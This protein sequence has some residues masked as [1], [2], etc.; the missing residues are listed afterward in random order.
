MI[1]QKIAYNKDSAGVIVDANVTFEDV[2]VES[3]SEESARAGPA[4]AIGQKQAPPYPG[5]QHSVAIGAR[6]V[7]RL[8]HWEGEG[9]VRHWKGGELSGTGRVLSSTGRGGVQS[10]GSRS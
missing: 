9:T 2:K 8:R 1:Y 7:R 6:A 3:W 10:G 5:Q 4:R